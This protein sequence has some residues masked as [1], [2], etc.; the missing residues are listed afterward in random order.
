MKNR[1]SITVGTLA[2]VS[3]CA[4]SL[5]HAQS[6][7]MKAHVPFAFVA[8]KTQMPAG[9]YSVYRLLSSSVTLRD[10]TTNRT[11]TVLT[12]SIQ[13]SERNQKACLVFHRYG[14]AYILKE[15]WGAVNR[16]APRFRRP[17]L[18]G[19]WKPAH[20]K[21][22]PKSELR[23]GKPYTLSAFPSAAR[24]SPDDRAAV[25]PKAV[26]AKAPGHASTNAQLRSHETFH[27]AK[28]LRRASSSQEQ[29]LCDP[30][31]TILVNI[32]LAP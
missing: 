21:S 18:S 23:P 25:F 14:D 5:G 3:L 19:S 11:A 22:W 27:P 16:S 17:K 7:T 32:A 28:T 2:F 31:R 4:A 9:E 20:G 26:S 6:L 30:S 12:N 29:W 24:S 8:G 1:I 15:A 13:R 10:D